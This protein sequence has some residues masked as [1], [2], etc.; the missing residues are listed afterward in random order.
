MAEHPWL[1]AYP[2][3]IDWHAEIPVKPLPTMLAD[4]VARYP[5]N[6]CLDFLGKTYTYAEISGLVDCA[7]A[8]LQKLGVS[9]GSRVG[10][11]LPNCPQFVIC[12][13]AALKAGATVIS[14]SPLY[15]EDE[16][17]NQINDS[18]T[19]IMITLDL[20]VL[21]PKIAKMVGTTTL[22][23]LVVGTM[24]EVLPFPKSL[25]FPLVKRGDIAK[26][27]GTNKIS[28]ADLIANDGN[29]TPVELDPSDLAVLQYTGGTTGVP[30]GAMLSHANL[31]A[32]AH[33]AM[34]WLEGVELGKE[35]MMGVLPFFHIFA[36]SVVMNLALLIGGAIIMHPRFELEAVLKDI[37]K[38]RPTLLPGVPTMYAAINNSPLTQ[39]VDV[40]SIKYCVSG[41]APLPVE[42]KQR[43][44]GITGCTLIEGY[45]L[46]ETS[47]IAAA[48]PLFSENKAGS[49]GQPVPGTT[50]TIVDRDDRTK[51]MPQGEKGEVCISGPQVMSG[52]WNQPTETENTL[53]NGRLHTGDIGY[54]DEQGYT[55]LIDRI[56]DLILVGGFNV[57]PRVVE[58][59][60]YQHTAVAEVTVVGLPDDI[61]GQRIK[62]F[63]KLA[64]GA[65]LTA[66]E[67]QKFLEPKIGKNEMPKDIEFRDELPKTLV[68]KLS[69]KELVAEEAAKL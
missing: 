2:K 68:G 22:K 40:T 67:L 53:V 29:P 56:K 8:G 37:T 51:E 4:S 12:F 19:E 14:Y 39:G 45:G 47:P 15:A 61:K 32:N 60:I 50:I 41:G 38:K 13:F 46:T 44:E 18:G 58:E 23:Q 24:Q 26:T 52:Y 16:I 59:A 36:L 48:N 11:F 17:R 69:K 1:A 10:L 49:V 31:Y 21:Y 6:Q 27:S 25:L 55:F 20:K 7:A 33:Q 66:E 3:N 57:F 63:V 5:N 62:A 34:L 54:M 9:K 42:V 28:F 30:K 65:A 64:D 43:F 35:R